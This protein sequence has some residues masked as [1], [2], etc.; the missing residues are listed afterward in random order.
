[1]TAKYLPIRMGDGP[2]AIQS[3]EKWQL[4]LIELRKRPDYDGKAQ[5]IEFA[6]RSLAD[7]RCFCDPLPKWA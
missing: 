5:D 2:D 4:Y 1:M 6:E 3:P 7:A